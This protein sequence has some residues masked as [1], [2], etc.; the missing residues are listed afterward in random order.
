M[1]II[2]HLT[3]FITGSKLYPKTLLK[4]VYSDD[5]NRLDTILDE[6]KQKVES[7]DP[8]LS[9]TSEN[10]VQNKVITSEIKNHT[11]RIET[12]ESFGVSVI[13]GKL[14]VTYDK[15]GEK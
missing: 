1:A 10:P 3:D 12:L 5:G 4:A 11:Q 2:R 6:L 8:A 7:V 9:E 15:E 13:D 14:N